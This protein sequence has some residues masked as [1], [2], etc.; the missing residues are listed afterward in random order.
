MFKKIKIQ[1]FKGITNLELDDFSRVNLFVGKNNCGKTAL[2]ESLFI[3]TAPASL[4]LN[5]K[6]NTFRGYPL[7]DEIAW[8]LNFR[9]LKKDLPI[10]ITL[11]Q[12]SREKRELLINPLV[13]HVFDV[14]QNTLT[15]VKLTAESSLSQKRVN[16]LTGEYSIKNGDNEKTINLK[17]T[18]KI[19][20]N[21]ILL[22]TDLSDNYVETLSAAFL[23]EVTLRY[24]QDVG[25]RFSEIEIRKQKTEIINV[26]NRLENKLKDVT[27][28]NQG[29]LYG[30][31]GFDTYLPLNIMGDGIIRLLSYLLAIYDT[32][33][34]IVLIDE[35][36]NGFHHESLKILWKAIFKASKDFDVRDIC[37]HSL[38]RKC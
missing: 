28:G 13:E 23:N 38:N 36:E 6:V 10:H 22:N 37:Y 18:P 24:P 30:D 27:Y 31:I 15:G 20:A 29:V 2:L 1:D 9:G 12:E 11:E 7:V 17:I 16:G 4:E 8:L 19:T 3:I 25:R 5:L 26:L 14:D 33:G 32:K 21:Q 34:G 35:I